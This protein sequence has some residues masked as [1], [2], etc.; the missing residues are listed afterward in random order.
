MTSDHLEEHCSRQREQELPWCARGPLRLKQVDGVEREE[1]RKTGG[2]PCQGSSGVTIRP[3]F[4][5]E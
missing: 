1:G 2:E 4:Y 3:G 5:S